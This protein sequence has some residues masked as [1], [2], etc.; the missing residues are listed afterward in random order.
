MVPAVST[1][2]DSGGERRRV[3]RV[4]RKARARRAASQAQTDRRSNGRC[5]GLRMGRGDWAVVYLVV[6]SLG[7]PGKM[8]GD[9]KG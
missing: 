4:G 8:W 5:V 9:L 3:S 1:Q 7:D 2:L 6:E